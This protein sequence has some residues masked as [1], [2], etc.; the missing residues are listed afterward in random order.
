MSLSQPALQQAVGQLAF[1]SRGAGLVDITDQVQQWLGREHTEDGLLT[2]FLQH[3]SA[4]LT[5]QENADPDVQADLMTALDRLA[6]RDAG[7]RHRTEGADDMPAHV[8]AMLTGVNLAVPVLKGRMALGVWQAI[9]LVEHR[10]RP[11]RRTLAL[12]F[13]GT[14]RGR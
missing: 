13:L 7:W 4:S 11:H 6:P 2:L 14:R 8:R 3:T 10:D 5:I 12:H 1:T 9:Y